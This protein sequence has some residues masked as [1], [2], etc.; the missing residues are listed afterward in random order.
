[1]QYFSAAQ[2][3]ESMLKG[4]KKIFYREK[5]K[6]KIQEKNLREK[7]KNIKKNSKKFQEFF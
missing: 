6:R 3:V 5:F 2:W 4:P 7:F 1:M